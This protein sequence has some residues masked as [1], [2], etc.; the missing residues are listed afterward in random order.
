MTGAAIA[1]LQDRFGSE[2]GSLRLAFGPCI[3]PC[4]FEVGGE[5]VEALLRAFPDASDCVLAG[6]PRRL[7]LVEAN[8][9]QARAA[10]VPEGGMQAAGLCTFCRPDLLVS[11]RRE[12]GTAGR[13]AG[14]IAWA[15]SGEEVR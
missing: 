4:C 1:T 9:M 3:G 11:Y 15:E 7:D 5:V 8:R 10:G 12:G 13:M 14:V 6:P 2:P